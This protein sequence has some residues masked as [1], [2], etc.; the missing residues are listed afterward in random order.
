MDFNTIEEKQIIMNECGIYKLYRYI[1]TC[2]WNVE[3][4]VDSHILFKKRPWTR[5][6]RTSEFVL[7]WLV[8]IAH[9]LHNYSFFCCLFLLL[10]KKIKYT[11]SQP[12]YLVTIVI[13]SHLLTSQF[14]PLTHLFFGTLQHWKWREARAAPFTP[15]FDSFTV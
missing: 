5:T 3:M 11:Q 15:L 12:V 1:Y 6:C 14:T 4:I 7:L 10:S 13:A 2:I 9:L 8:S